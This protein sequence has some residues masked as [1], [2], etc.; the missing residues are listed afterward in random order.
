MKIT[1][2]VKPKSKREYIKRNGNLEFTVAVN[3]VPEKGKA[4]QAVIK[5]LAEFFN[6][7]VSSITLI[8]GQAS[9]Q[10]VFEIPVTL[11]DLERLPGCSNQLKLL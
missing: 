6:L 1:V 10:K 9:R 2:R 3:E 5:L 8:S 11:E 4:N 7:T